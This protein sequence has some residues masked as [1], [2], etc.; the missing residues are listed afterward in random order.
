MKDKYSR[1][2]LRSAILKRKRFSSHF[3]YSNGFVTAAVLISLAGGGFAPAADLLKWDLPANSLGETSGSLPIFSAG[4]SG[5]VITANSAGLTGASVTAES[6]YWCLRGF[7]VTTSFGDALAAG[8]YYSFTTTAAVGYDVSFTGAGNSSIKLGSTGP[9]NVALYYSVDDITYN[10]VVSSTLTSASDTNVGAV[11]GSALAAN[12]IN[13]AS[14]ATG[15]WRV[16][17]YGGTAVTNSSRLRWLASAAVDFSLTG[18]STPNFIPHNLLWTGIGGN[19]WNT[20]PTNTNWADTDLANAA[21][22]FAINDNVTIASPVT[23]TVDPNG[24]VASGIAV[25]NSTGTVLLD[26]G[27]INGL[28]LS[29]TGAGTLCL[30]GTHSFT[31]GTTINGGVLQAE[32][33]KALGSSNISIDA[34]TLKTTEAVIEIVN[35]LTL[36]ASGATLETANFVTFS[37]QI[38]SMSTALNGSNRLTKTGEGALMFNK[39]GTN[40]FGTQTAFGAAGGMI[41]FDINAGGDVIFSGSGQRNLGGSNTWDSLVYLDGGTL[42]LHGGSISGIGDIRVI[43]S[44]TIGAL[45][46]YGASGISNTLTVDSAKVLTLDSDVVAQSFSLTGD[47]SGAGGIK[48]SGNGTVRLEGANSYSGGT[49]ILLNGGNLLLT[50]SEALGSGPLSVAGT[51]AE[52]GT[53]QLSNGIDITGV[54]SVSLTQRLAMNA[55]P[56]PGAAQIENLS[57][58]NSLSAP[59]SIVAPGGNSCNIL[60]TSGTLTLSGTLKNTVTASTRPFTFSGAGNF[61]VT[62]IIEDTSDT[63]KTSIIKFGS[64]T[65]SLSGGNSFTG[66]VNLNGGTNSN[67]NP[68]GNIRVKSN[69][70]LGADATAATVDMTFSTG[71]ATGAVELEGGV[72]INNKL[73]KIGGRVVAAASATLRNVSGSNTW[74]GGISINNSGGGYPIDNQAGTLTLG[75]TLANITSAGRGFVVY[76]SGNTLI[77]GVIANTST[78]ITTSITLSGT[79]TMTLS[80][81]NTHTYGTSVTQGT[82]TV[83]NGGTLGAT[84]V[85][86]TVSN[87]NTTAAG[88]ASILNLSTAANT[89]TGS[90]AGTVSTPPSGTNTATINTQTGRDFTVNQTVAGTYAGVIAGPGS[91]TLGSLSTNTLTLSGTNTY[92]GSTTVN[93]GTLKLNTAYLDDAAALTVASGAVLNLN[94]A[95]TDIVGSL[96]LGGVLQP[97]GTYDAANSNGRITGTGKIQVGAVAAVTYSTWAI[98]NAGGQGP[99]SDFDHDGLTNLVEYALADGTIGVLTAGTLSFTKRSPIIADATYAIEQSTDLVQWAVVTPT[100][101]TASGISYTLPT[102]MDRKFIRLKITQIP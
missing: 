63:I 39:T 11:F 102:G 68:V 27:S 82:L 90:L 65:L 33:S 87:S 91:V 93:A 19:D 47:I 26:G 13:L 70:A 96:T 29:K 100:T 62:G 74:N 1:A 81:V 7:D 71:V 18:T 17:A 78:A 83:S 30:S 79:G 44:S 38:S 28:A 73:L 56:A 15:Y 8:D 97:N 41:E 64:G 20:T 46:D 58:D 2:P 99:A 35:P 50:N 98:L 14:G 67:T 25:L 101:E 3:S 88:T 4:I 94:H 55:T 54:S 57:G 22:P 23:I 89:V 92:T 32:N 76:G 85:P 16:V 77:T 42:K 21:A 34:A 37:G 36:G 49:S 45:L 12:P 5:S 59:I 61:L 6:T 51:A 24:V 31:L 53:L 69:T 52:K 75:G 80:G 43:T 95:G 60:S 86:I 10:Q 48:K 84:T 40:A 9:V 66:G 72:T